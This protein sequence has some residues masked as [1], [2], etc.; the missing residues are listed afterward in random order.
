M[1][2]C[3]EGEKRTYLI[4]TI[5]QTADGAIEPLVETVFLLVAIRFFAV[6][7]FWKGLISASKFIGFFVSAPLTG[8]LNRTGIPR[9]RILSVLT[10]FSSAA[11]A[12]G[13]LSGSGIAY[14]FAVSL[15]GAAYHLRQPFFTDLYSEAYPP[16]RRARRIS[17]GLRLQMLLSLGSG[18]LYSWLLEQSI[19]YWR[20]ILGYAVIMTSI[21]ALI[22]TYLPESEPRPRQ[23]RWWQILAMPFSNPVFLYVQSAWMIIGFGNLWTLPLRAV[24]LA[25]KERG[26]GLSPA[27]VIVILVIIPVALRFL[28]NPIWARLYQR[29]SFPGLRISINLFFMTSI[30]LFFLTDKVWII[31]LA[32]TLFG[33][34]TSGSPF[35]WQ[36]WV[37]RIVPPS[38]TRI[39]QSAHAFLAGIRGVTA[40]F[41]GLAVLQGLSFQSM[42][43]IS[44]GLAF[45]AT[46]M[47]IPLL[48]IDRKF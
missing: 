31:V 42:G 23:E 6:G 4:D 1:S 11:L 24:Y 17:L 7:D 34:G 32:S 45:F 35:I 19:G 21:T 3:T 22:L 8:I 40:P 39:Y 46:A 43:L 48:R 38:E 13:I 47:M 33:I 12:A 36:L 9:S 16:E 26:L 5:R 15:A 14:T 18:L 20:W 28:F 27:K 25:E 37:T 30:P 41:I 29:M 44:G 10:G 2:D